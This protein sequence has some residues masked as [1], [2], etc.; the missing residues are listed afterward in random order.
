MNAGNR[1]GVIS[2]LLAGY[3]RRGATVIKEARHETTKNG[4]ERG[5]RA[6]KTR[7]RKPQYETAHL[8][9]GGWS[10]RKGYVKSKRCLFWSYRA[11][12]KTPL[13]SS[14]EARSARKGTRSVSSVSWGS[15]N[16]EET[17]TALFG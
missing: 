9:V 13:T 16:Q 2:E 1:C 12:S 14:V 10:T 7:H 17:G 5:Y 11:P 6:I 8:W 4:K 15:L 3:I